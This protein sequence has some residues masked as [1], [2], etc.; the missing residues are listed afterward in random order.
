MHT[1]RRARLHRKT[2]KSSAPIVGDAT[3][4]TFARSAE[5]E[6]SPQI[7]RKQ[8]ANFAY[9]Y[10]VD[11]RA[12]AKGRHDMNMDLASRNRTIN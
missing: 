12:A 10:D 4:T 2:E 6:P 9:A 3:K 7:A 5:K 11:V 1:L 8:F